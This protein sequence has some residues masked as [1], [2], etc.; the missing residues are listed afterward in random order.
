MVVHPLRNLIL[1]YKGIS[2][3]YENELLLKKKVKEQ[4]FSWANFYIESR[5]AD[6]FGQWRILFNINEWDE[7]MTWEDLMYLI[8]KPSPFPAC[9]LS[10]PWYE[11]LMIRFSRLLVMWWVALVSMYHVESF[12]GCGVAIII[13]KHWGGSWPWKARS[14]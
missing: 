8:T 10:E 9:T 5:L 11:E 14:R 6:A 1:Y 7:V 3:K 2:I 4:L 12:V 13:V